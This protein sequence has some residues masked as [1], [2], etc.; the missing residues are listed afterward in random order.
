MT[1]KWD[2]LSPSE[3]EQLQECIQYST[4][5]LSD[6]LDSEFKESGALWRYNPEGDMDLEGFQRFMDIYLEVESPRELIKRLFLSFVKK[7]VS[8]INKISVGKHCVPSQSVPEG[9]KL[10]TMAAVT[11]TTAC[12][13]ITSHNTTGGSLPELTHDIIIQNYCESN[14]KIQRRIPYITA[15]VSTN[16]IQPLGD[17]PTKFTA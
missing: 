12:A 15:E 11:S 16:R 7:N 5:K 8:P 1:L 13:P 4:K 6:V 9:T 2:K 10:L 3:F 17:S 14:S